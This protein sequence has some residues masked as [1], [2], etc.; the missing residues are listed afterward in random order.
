MGGISLCVWVRAKQKIPLYV[1]ARNPLRGLACEISHETGRG[2]G[3][4]GPRVKRISQEKEAER[5]SRQ[6]RAVNISRGKPTARMCGPRCRTSQHEKM[7]QHSW[8]LCGNFAWIH[9]RDSQQMHAERHKSVKN[10]LLA[11]G[12]NSRPWLFVLFPFTLSIV[13]VVYCVSVKKCDIPLAGDERKYLTIWRS[14]V[15]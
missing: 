15:V 4:E 9:A 3:K 8:W 12:S 5:R 1:L 7:S 6:E 14:W 2:R 13:Y 10:S 11:L